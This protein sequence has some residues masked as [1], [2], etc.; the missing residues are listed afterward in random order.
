MLISLQVKNFAIIEQL[1]VYFKEHLNI[2]TGETGAGKSIIIGSIQAALGG[3]V[4]KDMIRT[5]AD[6]AYVELLF[7]VENAKVMNILIIALFFI[8]KLEI[9]FVVFMFDLVKS[10]KKVIITKSDYYPK[11]EGVFRYVEWFFSF[12]RRFFHAFYLYSFIMSALGYPLSF[13]TSSI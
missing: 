5:N 3:K 10:E 2:L 4:S 9:S 8:W 12:N 6:Y 7:S 13:L 11:P 1:E